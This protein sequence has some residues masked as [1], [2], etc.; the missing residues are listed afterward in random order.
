MLQAANPKALIFFTAL[1]PQFID[2]AAPVWPQVLILGASSVIAEWFILAAYG[3]FAGRA[4]V[5]LRQ[6]AYARTT[7][8]VAGALLA[9]A[10]IGLALADAK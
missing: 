7:D 1:L 8:R 10:G 9:G 4:A 5:R 6:P 3:F 2:R